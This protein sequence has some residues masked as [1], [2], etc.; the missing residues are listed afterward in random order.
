VSVSDEITAYLRNPSSFPSEYLWWL[1]R[2]VEDAR[3]LD[4]LPTIPT[5][6]TVQDIAD[7]LVA[8][9]LAKQA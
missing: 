1:H 9:G 2:F 7:V 4:M 5:T 8:L 6:P 3:D